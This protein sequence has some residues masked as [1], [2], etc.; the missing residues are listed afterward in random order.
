[1]PPLRKGDPGYEN[2]SKAKN[3]AKRL[4]KGDPGYEN[5]SV[6]KNNAKQLRKGD[7]GYENSSVAKSSA[8]N[9]AK[10]IAKAA[11]RS[12]ASRQARGEKITYSSILDECERDALLCF[13]TAIMPQLQ[14][15]RGIDIMC[16]ADHR[17][18][19]VRS[20]PVAADGTTYEEH[21]LLSGLPYGGVTNDEAARW[22]CRDPSPAIMLLALGSMGHQLGCILCPPLAARSSRR[23]QWPV[24]R[25][26]QRHAPACAPGT[27]CGRA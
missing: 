20:S 4:R 27:R 3:N 12:D 21:I 1:M 25:A 22:A 14:A 15:G 9:N 18:R 6:A 13:D 5:S 23:P 16:M 19:P 11:A 24:W 26:G 2:S 7:P 10:S 8:K 17:L